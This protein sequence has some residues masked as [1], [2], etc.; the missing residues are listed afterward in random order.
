MSKK[1]SNPLPP[2]LK[3]PDPPPAPPA[4]RCPCAGCRDD[5]PRRIRIDQF[6]KGERAIWEATQAV[7]EM[8]CDVRLTEALIL[9]GKARDKVAD[10]ID[11]VE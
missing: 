8:G 6:S 9:L 2:N 5:Y 3:K 10:F 7:E 1:I 4:R 11:G